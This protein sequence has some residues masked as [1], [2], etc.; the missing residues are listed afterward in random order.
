M[1]YITV[2]HLGQFAISNQIVAD[3]LEFGFQI[4][5]TILIQIRFQVNNQVDDRDFDYYFSSFFQLKLIDFKL[6][7]IKR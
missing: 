4:G 2:S 3:D 6:F 1:F 7:S 5:M